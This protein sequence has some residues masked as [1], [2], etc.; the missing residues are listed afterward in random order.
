RYWTECHTC[1]SVSGVQVFHAHSY[2]RPQH[3]I[4]RVVKGDRYECA[5]AISLIPRIAQEHLWLQHVGGDL[6]LVKWCGRF[7][8]SMGY[9][10]SSTVI[11]QASRPKWSHIS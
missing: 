10:D 8:Q 4:A 6:L 3:S 7:A 2:R 5:L 11:L 9:S 1:Y